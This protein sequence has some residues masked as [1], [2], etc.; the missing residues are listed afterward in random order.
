MNPS[1]QKAITVLGSLNMDLSVTTDR[2][3]V[4]G[5]TRHG[6]DFRISPGGKG[7]NQAVSAARCGGRVHFVGAVGDDE[8]GRELR[9]RL[10]ACGIGLSG[11]KTLTGVPTGNAMIFVVNGDNSIIITAGANGAVSE[12]DLTEEILGESG[13]LLAQ[14][15]TPAAVTASAFRRAREKGILTVLNPAPAGELP[16]ELLRNT[17]ILVPNEIECGEITGIPITDDASVL[18]AFAVLKE[19][20][21]GTVIMT[22][23][24]RG[25]VCSAGTGSG[26][27][28]KIPAY[29]VTAV[30]TTAAG[31]SF[32]GALA[33]KLNRGC[34][35]EE[36][37]RYAGAVSAI[38]VTRR[39][40]SDSIP[41]QEETE[42]FLQ[43]HFLP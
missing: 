41:L 24:A 26:G 7:L 36:A 14:L 2:M 31:D 4:L 5:E 21:V 12:E 29:S 6:S 32:C 18:R 37:I 27:L 11:V 28:L 8:F 35:L 34:S 3:P 23:G 10:A 43:S 13:V 42:A 17:D 40:A 15:E 38:S 39:G 20:G 1:A 25:S 9:A 22:V 33:V 16:D 30:D 19:R